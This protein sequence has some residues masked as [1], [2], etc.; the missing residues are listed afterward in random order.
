MTSAETKRHGETPPRRFSTALAAKAAVGKRW[1]ASPS[2][3]SAWPRRYFGFFLIAMMAL[4]LMSFL[5]WQGHNDAMR[6]AEKMSRGVLAIYESHLNASLRRA[7]AALMDIAALARPYLESAQS[8]PQ[9]LGQTPAL[10]AGRLTGFSEI[11]GVYLIDASGILR[12]NSDSSLIGVDL[13]D[14]HY[15]RNLRDMPGQGLVASELL[16]LRTTGQPTV[17][18]ARAVLG[19]D[20]NFLG[21]VGITL[22]LG[23]FAELLA[24][25]DL[26][27]GGFLA[28]ARASD[29]QVLL[30]RPSMVDQESS[31]SLTKL[32][33]GRFMAAAEQTFL[34][35]DPQDGVERLISFRKV[36]TYPWVVVAG[37]SLNDI[38]A[39]WWLRFYG[40]LVVLTTL[41]LIGIALLRRSISA[42]RALKDAGAQ[43]ARLSLAVEQN[44]VSVV[45]TDLTGAIT[46]VNPAFVEMSGYSAAEA[47]GQKASLQ[48]SGHTSPETFASLWSA[49]SQGNI[50][51]GEFI[52]QR[53]DGQLRTHFAHVSPIRDA[54]GKVFSYL[55][56]QEDISERKAQALELDRHRHHL[57]ELVDEQTRQLAQAKEAAEAANLSKSAFLAN[58]S[59]E[60]RTPMNAIIGFTHLLQR[61]S[62]DEQQQNRLKQVASAAQ[63]LLSVIND[64]L[65]LSKIEAGKIALELGEFRVHTVFERVSNL[66]VEKA[67]EKGLALSSDIAP[68]LSLCLRGDALRLGQ[69]LLNFA[70]NAVKFTAQ[71][72]ISLHASLLEINAAR[73]LVRFAVSDTGT[74]IASADHERLFAA[75]E[76][77]DVSTTRRYG[78]T[79]LGL[80]ISRRL[81]ELMGGQ[82]GVNSKPGAGS[83]FWF[84]VWFDVLASD[85]A[86][87]TSS[88]EWNSG[89]EQILSRKYGGTPVLVVEDNLINQEIVCG[90]LQEIGFAPE[91]AENG[92]IAVELARSRP[93]ALILMDMLMPVMDG[94]DATRILRRMPAL[95]RVPILALTASAFDQDR[96]R[97]LAA[98]MDDHVGKPIDPDPFFAT[99]LRWLESGR[100]PA[101]HSNS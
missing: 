91:C 90:L 92:Q 20:Q 11:I 1:L 32:L 63:H 14:R 42:N 5:L 39:N 55:S 30:R 41:F 72:H 76:Q 60:I 78:G 93:Y 99:L 43:L 61:N 29:G 80:A 8:E 77:A 56:I 73:A 40:T 83:T 22:N 15:F 21:A 97:C 17:M 46:Y 48:S 59:H 10:M 70:S 6:S 7:D 3:K 86:D 101:S 18:L 51:R 100:L 37:L 45:I 69:I 95:E 47:L 57:R 4:S 58:M 9:P 16:H 31:S 38:L 81:V 62:P 49:L 85:C 67:G 74:G 53:R 24:K 2:S 98:G 89:A 87:C 66:I 33:H 26:G 50:W 82:I 68:E 88:V 84:T 75:F 28:I 44:P 94:I 79:G 13:S 96:E 71:G 65:D 36:E 25:V 27:P 12:Y 23:F 34:I 52:N 54:D 64:I 35:S 19:K